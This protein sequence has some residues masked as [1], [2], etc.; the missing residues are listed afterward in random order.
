MAFD[1]SRKRFYDD[2]GY[3]V[4]ERVFTESDLAPV[5]NRTDQI[6]RDPT[7]ASKGMRIGR[8]SDTQQPKPGEGKR[9]DDPVRKFESPA[10]FDPIFADFVRQTKL[11]ELVR[12]LIGPRIKLFRDQMLLKP[13]GGQDKPTHQDQSYFLV[14][15]M[16]ELVTAWVALD[17]ATLENGCMR[18]VPGSHKFGILEM[19]PDP[20][21]PVH[22]VPKTDGLNLKPEATCP[23]PAGSVIFHHGLTLHRSG[24]NNTQTWRKALALHFAT[25]DAKS[26]IGP[27]NKEVS[28]LID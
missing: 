2:N 19:H 20:E 24:V 25:V 8:E 9:T 28:L 14:R 1:Q 12:G 18:Y 16:D 22:H 5:R 3:L 23:V 7:A 27:L 21:R 10:R 6:L 17:D 4:V 15:P 13:P 26:E 11:L